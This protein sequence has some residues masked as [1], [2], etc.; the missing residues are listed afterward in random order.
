[1][2]IHNYGN[3]YVQ[4]RKFEKESVNNVENKTNG[5]ESAAS[6]QAQAKGEAAEE[7]TQ[8]KKFGKKKTDSSVGV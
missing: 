8:V 3:D 4:T 2:K 1:M 5:N 7:K 6:G